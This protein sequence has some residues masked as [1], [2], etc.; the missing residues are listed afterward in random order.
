MVSPPATQGII[1]CG[2]FS[3]KEIGC[4]ICGSK[5]YYR[6]GKGVDLYYCD[7]CKE[8]HIDHKKNNDEKNDIVVEML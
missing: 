7:D 2:T 1:S 4:P 6:V 8:E 5:A 3:Q